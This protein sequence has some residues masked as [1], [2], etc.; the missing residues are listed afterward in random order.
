MIPKILFSICLLLLGYPG[1]AHPIKIS[2][3]ELV[4]YKERKEFVIKLRFFCD[5]FVFAVN[6]KL[7]STIDVEK[8][9]NNT[10]LKLNKFVQ[11][12]FSLKINN[13]KTNPKY[14][15]IS[16]DGEA[17]TLE[18]VLPDIGINYISDIEIYYPVLMDYFKDQ[19]NLF[20][21]DLL[22]DGNMTT[23]RYYTG[24]NSVK[25]SFNQKIF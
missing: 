19:Q 18:Y 4:Y 11:P 6:K 13:K 10:G 1:A 14:R 8:L 22:N 24:V 12:Y 23:F 5:D 7:N 15:R 9:D 25:Q 16:R 3:G 21:V 2:T 17:I 20:R